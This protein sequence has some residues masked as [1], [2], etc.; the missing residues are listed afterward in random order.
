MLQI[1]KR[2]MISQSISNKTALETNLLEQLVR[3]VHQKSEI[4]LCSEYRVVASRTKFFYMPSINILLL[5]KFS[6]KISL[7]DKALIG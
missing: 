4:R 3:S 1:I 6:Y 7:F 5:F 2:V